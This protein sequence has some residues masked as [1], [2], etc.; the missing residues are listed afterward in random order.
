MP[1]TAAKVRQRVLPTHV[2]HGRNTVKLVDEQKRPMPR[3]IEVR[4]DMS[5]RR[6]YPDGTKPGEVTGAYCPITWDPN[7][8]WNHG[9]SA[10]GRG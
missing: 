8:P 2:K 3:E 10:Q 6:R 1:G 7:S 9:P 5:G 4:V